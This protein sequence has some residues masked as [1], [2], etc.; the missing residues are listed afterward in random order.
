MIYGS[1]DVASP[2]GMVGV[3]HNPAITIF[4]AKKIYCISLW[5]GFVTDGN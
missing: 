5:V 2:V 3:H 1:L 4:A